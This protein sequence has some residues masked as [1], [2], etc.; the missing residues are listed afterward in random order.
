M[1]VQMS[2]VLPPTKEIVSYGLL[3]WPK[4]TAVLKAGVIARRVLYKSSGGG[5]F[6]KVFLCGELLCAPMCVCVSL[7]HLT[8][9]NCWRSPELT[10]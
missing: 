2:Q 4:L 9:W 3:F 8:D 10:N 6:C 1:S 7:V 5:Y